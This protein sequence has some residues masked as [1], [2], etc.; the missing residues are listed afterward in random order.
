MIPRGGQAGPSTCPTFTKAGN[1]NSRDLALHRYLFRNSVRQDADKIDR[2]LSHPAVAV[3]PITVESIEEG[4]K[5]VI[6]DLS[7]KKPDGV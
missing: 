5:Y 1:Q 3:A 4:D 2:R 7:K 6:L